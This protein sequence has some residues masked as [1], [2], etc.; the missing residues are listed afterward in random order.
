M[1]DICQELT[2]T[3]GCTKAFFLRYLGILENTAIIAW[4]MLD[5]SISR[6]S[7]SKLFVTLSRF[8][9]LAKCLKTVGNFSIWVNGHVKK[10]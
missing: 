2:V 3:C 10:K 8:W 6:A 1:Q 5:M 9:L 7:A 4:Y